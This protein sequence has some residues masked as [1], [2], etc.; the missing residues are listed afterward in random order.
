MRQARYYFFLIAFIA[1]L[2]RAQESPSPAS[3]NAACL[4]CH[5]STAT[6]SKLRLKE[7]HLP[8]SVHSALLCTDCHAVKAGERPGDIPHQEDI[9]SPD[10]TSSC[11]REDNKARPGLDPLSYPDSVH[12]RAYLERGV[13]EVAKCWDCHGKHNIRACTDPESTVHRKNIPQTCTSC[14]EDM[15]VVVKYHI[16]RE[17]PYQEYMKSVHGKALFEKGLVQFAAVCTDCHGVHDIKGVG[18]PHLMARQPQTCGR[19]HELI[20]NEYKDSIHGQQ[21]LAGNIDSPLCVDCHGEHGIASPKDEKSPVFSKNI[22]DTCSACH[23]R[24]EIM[25]KYGI[26]ED[27]ITT[28]IDSLHGIA[29]GFGSTAAATCA[30]CHGVHDI[31]PASDPRSKINPA[32]LRSTCG[33][34]N[35]HPQMPEKIASSKIHIG[36]ESKASPAL[37]FI[38]RVLIILV[39]SLLFITVVWFIPGFV[40]KAKLLRK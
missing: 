36:P 30:S 19:C 6:A 10:C 26:S 29:V 2:L 17:M 34:V 37:F 8:A 32:N 3:P 28:F 18:E 35:C 9:P 5:G 7:S 20:F 27:K 1:P 23:A 31:R 21:A 13:G 15:A 39:I 12:G 33:Q 25:K 4:A 22:P 24:P 16:H 38:Q 14:H 11:H 40:R